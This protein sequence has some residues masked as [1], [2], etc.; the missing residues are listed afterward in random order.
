MKCPEVPANAMLHGGFIIKTVRLYRQFSQKDVC[1]QYGI[2]ERTLRNW[3]REK[4][5]PHFGH[6]Q[7]ICEDIFS[8]PLLDAIVMAKDE[9]EKGK[10]GAT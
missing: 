6:V 4:Q 2:T 1:F 5:D 9:L 10:V 3:E 8:V 7:A